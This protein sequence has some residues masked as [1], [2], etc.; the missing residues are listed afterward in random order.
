MSLT[1]TLSSWAQ[2]SISG[3]ITDSDGEAL[4]GVSIIEKGT[5][6]GVLT[7]AQGN[8]KLSISSSDATIVISYAGFEEQEVAVAGRST[9]NASLE[10]LITLNVQ[11]VGSRSYK[12]S[13]TDTPTA[14]DVIDVQ[15][16]TLRNGNAELN[17]IL[18][19]L[20]P[21]FNAQKQSGSDGAEHIDPASL[22]GL[23]PDQTLVLVNG[24]RRHQSSL[25]NIFGTRGRGNTGTDMNA[26]PASAIERIEILRDGA[27]AQYGSD[28]IAGVI[29]IVLRSETNKLTGSITAGGFNPI[30]PDEFGLYDGST[31]NTSGNFLDLDGSGT[32]TRS[33]DPTLDG[34]TTKIAANYGF[35]I[36]KKGGFANITT[37]FINKEKTLRPGATFRRGM[38]EAEISGFA[39][40]INSV[41]PVGDETEFYLFG[42][43][44]YRDTDAFAFTRNA[45]DDRAVPS[46]YP[47]GFTP[48]ITS[49]I[50][51]NSLSAG[52]RKSL[53]GGWNADFNNTI[54]S[55]VFH[56]FIK[57]TNNATLG[58]R[59]PTDF[60]AG[61]HTL[62]QNTTS[63]D[64]SKYFEQGEGKGMNIA[65]GL[66][67]RTDNFT[68]FAGEPGSYAAYDVNGL[69]ITQ[70]DQVSTGLA[71]GS[72]GFPG[73]S[74]ANEVDRNRSNFAIYGDAEFDLSR[75]F[76]LNTALR[77]ENYTDFGST[78]NWK[79]ASRFLASDDL[80]IRA[81]VSTGFRAPSLAQIYY[82]LRFTSF[83]N[84]VLTE[85]LL[86]ANN[87][88]VTAGFGIQPLKQEE[89]FNASV[90]F[91]YGKG[92]FTLTVD[93]YYIDITDRIVITGN[94]DANFL[95]Q[96]VETAQFFANAADTRSLG[97]DVVLSYRTDL[98]NGHRFLASLAGN[99]NDLEVTD[100][101][102][103]NLEVE[104]FFGGRE[105]SL[106]E[107]AAPASKFAL[108][109]N[110]ITDNFNIN[111]GATNFG[112]VSYFSFDNVTPVVY[113][114]KTVFDLTGTVYFSKEI[115]LTLGINN[116][117]NTYPTQQIA[118]D[119]TDSGGY[120]D[121]VQMGFGGTYYFARLGFNF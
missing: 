23:G 117:F 119:N 8:Y 37:E 60:D 28:A 14:V 93:G 22:R 7:D 71:A 63:L 27:A 46:I 53:A 82:N 88:P 113:D 91:A 24:K 18:Q 92:P 97:L 19:Y 54:G 96:G 57:G 29:N 31:P 33:D 39:G 77:F 41:I 62:T 12:R 89:S 94:F 120:F 99:L 101:K 75:Q 10:D 103:G 20:A 85:S 55:N 105:V 95:N 79:V 25:I 90:G 2:H 114:A 15:E 100:I 1:I 13:S 68:I 49:I 43:R 109:L 21:S 121:A 72:Q 66:E 102:N 59:S 64:F 52:F 110:Y 112:K 87:S 6:T 83:V 81:A 104:T 45:G 35:D 30:A 4:Q 11:I 34:L 118:S 48:R 47:N 50:T 56:Y 67:Y 51:D 115:N 78:L 116:I 108:N 40:F 76:L 98:D 58:D 65:F 17:K 36:G 3:T 106:L 69:I 61:G 9:I 84:G 42:G 32:T 80:T 38:G 5:T 86:S 111:L 26:I 74:P 70:P 16:V 44:N 107:D 73:Y